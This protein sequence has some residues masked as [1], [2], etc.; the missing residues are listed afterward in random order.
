MQDRP[1]RLSSRENRRAP[2]APA[3][4]LTSTLALGL[5]LA[6]GGA[7]VSVTRRDRA[8][9]GGESAPR[10]GIV[11]VRWRT[12]IH[13]RALFQPPPEECA[14]GALAGDHL[15]IGSRGASVVG[16]RLVDG[17]IDWSTKVSGGIDSD[18]RFDEARGQVF[19]G[20]DDGSFYA[21]D[22][23]G[24]RIRYTYMAKGAIERAAELGG[25][26]VYLAS[27]SDRVI[28]L[29]AATGKW[30]WQ[31]ERET[32]DGFTI[33]GYSAPA[34][35]GTQVLAGFSDGYLVALQAATGEVVWAKSLA[36]A[37]DQFV[38]VDSTPL[39]AGGTVFA[40]SYSGGVYGL[41][42]KDGAVKWRLPTE[43]AGQLS[44]IGGDLFFAAPRQGL[45]A[46]SSSGR[47]LWRQGLAEAGDLTAPLVLGHFLV[48]SGS[49]GGL[50]VIDSRDGELLEVFNPG[51]G[52]CAS[53]TLDATHSRIYVLSNGGTLYAL[54]LG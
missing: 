7:C 14:S 27:A 47:I 54:D 52:I 10:A 46:V 6:L 2:R 44:L 28:A 32:P 12:E 35:H 45:H 49:R 39:V 15:V 37:S 3:V 30:R 19:L 17:H 26:A 53:A 29:D 51:D 31:Y 5:A 50:F 1:H 4:A 40:A 8:P 48:F 42:E 23:A 13:A 9:G 25:D 36:A 20:A 24:G 18:A 21:V 22:A 11:H 16:V 43:G 34:L 41:D 38:D 33:H